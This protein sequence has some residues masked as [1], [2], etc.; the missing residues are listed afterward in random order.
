MIW[1]REITK[2][3]KEDLK[4]LQTERRNKLRL[5][6]KSYKNQILS[7]YMDTNSEIDLSDNS[8]ICF[9]NWNLHFGQLLVIFDMC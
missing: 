5:S 1:K 8:M 2:V 9:K 4:C 7:K 6:G 3:G